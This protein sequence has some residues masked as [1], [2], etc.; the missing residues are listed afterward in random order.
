VTF[1]LREIIQPSI[2]SN[3]DP[4]ACAHELIEKT[5]FGQEV[6]FSNFK[7]SDVA[8]ILFPNVLFAEDIIQLIPLLLFFDR[9]LYKNH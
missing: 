6:C 3:T 5:L 4:L 7:S 8:V 2:E 1:A 9:S